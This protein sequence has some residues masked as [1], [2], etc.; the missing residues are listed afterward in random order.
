MELVRIMLRLLVSALFITAGVM[1]FVREG[2][3]LKIMP[4]YLPYH[5]EI[6]W[7][8]G[9]FEV[10]GG[11]GLLIPGLRVASAWGLIA[12]LIAVFPANIHVYLHQEI[13]PAPG[14]VHFLRLPLQ[15]VLIALVYWVG[16]RARSTT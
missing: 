4:P 15:G 9:L 6:V 2:F 11:V 5:R 16:I 1:H 10:I 3:F 12:L 7:I 14:W 13:M 8:S